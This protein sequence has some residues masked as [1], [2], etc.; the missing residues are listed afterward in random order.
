[1]TTW[2]LEAFRELEQ[3]GL[4]DWCSTL[5]TTQQDRT[6]SQHGHFPQW[7]AAIASLPRIG[8]A[9]VRLDVEAVTLSADVSQDVRDRIRN[10]LQQFHPW[11]KGPFD[12][13]GVRVDAEWQSNWKFD[14][15]QPHLAW[16]D[17]TVLDVGCG[18]GYYGY[19]MLGQGARFVV[20]LEPYP[21]Y[22]AQFAAIDALLPKLRNHVVP[23][24]DAAM[25]QP[26]QFF[27][28]VVS[29]GVLYHC[30]D[31]LGHL[32]RLR[33]AAA[34][35]GQ[36]VMET[37]VV[38]GDEQTVLMPASRYAKMR[39]VWFLPSVLMLERMLL[40]SGFR[41][42]DVVDITR[43]TTDEQRST[44]W[45]P[46]ESLA[47]FLDPADHSRTIEGLPSPQRVIMIA[48]V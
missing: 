44:E 17:K 29:M 9:E 11:R 16:Q 7:Q 33:L 30:R 37:M 10:V 20:G 2:T 3:A 4:N 43:T 27:D 25:L 19:R 35:G 26:L 46:F 34:P 14:R 6:P 41:S 12:V 36:V 32:S 40:R 18:N 22:N 28:L 24:T 23:A 5:R 39:N 21:L 47:D 45:M 1:M 42:V 8:P 15:L 48:N 13:C 31:P 38:D